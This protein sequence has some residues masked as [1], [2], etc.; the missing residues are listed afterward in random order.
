MAKGRSGFLFNNVDKATNLLR[1]D[2][3][4]LNVYKFDTAASYIVKK[5]YQ[6][7]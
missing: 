4:N 5:P 6:M 2:I 3:L 7:K 1:I